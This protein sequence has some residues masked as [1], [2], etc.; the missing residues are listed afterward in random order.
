MFLYDSLYFH[1]IPHFLASHYQIKSQVSSGVVSLVA[2]EALE[3]VVA[4]ETDSPVRSRLSPP[5]VNLTSQ[6]VTQGWRLLD[7]DYL[8]LQHLLLL[9]HHDYL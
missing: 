6:L 7:E 2:L 4:I 5:L 8:D 3:Y 1:H 9:Q